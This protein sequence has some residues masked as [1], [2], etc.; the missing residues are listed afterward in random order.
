[1]EFAEALKATRPS[2]GAQ[3]NFMYDKMIPTMQK[4]LGEIRDLVTTEQKRNILETYTMYPT[5]NP[6]TSTPF[7][8]IE[9]YKY[10]SL[11]GLDEANCF[12]EDFPKNSAARSLLNQYITAG[13][14][15]LDR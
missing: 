6:L 2:T 10:I 4:V 9:F 14:S 5:S 15:E 11:S 13:K 1:M 12:K 8:W 7:S 3:H